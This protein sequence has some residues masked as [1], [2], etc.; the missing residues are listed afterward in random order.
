[1]LNIFLFLYHGH[2]KITLY[3]DVRL[4]VLQYSFFESNDYIKIIKF[5]GFQ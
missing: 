4:F 1:M 3:D 2:L 5:S